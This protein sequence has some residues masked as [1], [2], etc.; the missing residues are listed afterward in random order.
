MW[1]TDK[2]NIHIGHT[3]YTNSTMNQRSNIIILFHKKTEYLLEQVKCKDEADLSGWEFH[4]FN[5][6]EPTHQ[7]FTFHYNNIILEL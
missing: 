1:F 7:T 4:L 6:D 5:S 3:S 2:D